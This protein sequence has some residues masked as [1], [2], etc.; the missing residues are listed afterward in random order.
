MHCAHP[1]GTKHYDAGLFEARAICNNCSE[2]AKDRY[3]KAVGLRL[4]DGLFGSGDEM[5]AMPKPA[6]AARDLDGPRRVA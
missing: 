1:L 5:M 6:D 2:S 4:A 3:L